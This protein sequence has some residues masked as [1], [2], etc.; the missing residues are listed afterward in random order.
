MPNHSR[1]TSTPASVS[2]PSSS[3]SSILT[4]T[5][6]ALSASTTS[7]SIS[8]SY[9]TSLSR[10]P[11][12]S[13]APPPSRHGLHVSRKSILASFTSSR[14][15]NSLRSPFSSF[16]SVTS[17]PA[18]HPSQISPPIISRP[19]SGEDESESYY[20]LSP[21]FSP[22]GGTPSINQSSRASS[23]P[24]GS[25]RTYSN[26][27]SSVD[28]GNSLRRSASL[29]SVGSGPSTHTRAP[30]LSRP[31]TSPNKHRSHRRSPSVTLAVS[32]SSHDSRLPGLAQASKPILHIPTFT[33]RQK[34]SDNF[35][36]VAGEGG[37]SPV[38]PPPSRFGP[39]PVQRGNNPPGRPP[40]T[41][42]SNLSNLSY[43]TSGNG[44]IGSSAPVV[45]A[46]VGPGGLNP[47]VV[48]Q[49]ILD[50]ASKRISTLDY[51]RKA[52]EG[53][54][55]W[56]NTLLFTKADL[57]KLPYFAAPKLARRATSYL[58]LGFSLPTVLDLNAHSA[59]DYLRALN[60]LLAEFEAYQALHPPDGNG[61][62][63]SSL[64]RA[65]IPAMFKRA[66]GGGG[67]ARRASSA[68]ESL[69]GATL[70]S[71]ADH[72]L[73]GLGPSMATDTATSPSAVAP[74]AADTL[75][76]TESYTHLLTPPLPF[77]PDFFETFATLCDVLIDCYTR[78]TQLVAGPEVV[79]Q[80][81]GIGE[82]FAKADARVR[83]VILASAVREFEE[84]CRE[85]VRSECKGVGRVVLGGLI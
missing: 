82:L 23:P 69:A 18:P 11:S 57:L 21:V 77:D 1:H 37:F 38:E 35:R 2:T 32:L 71:D 5:S 54:V 53:R 62:S 45:P 67:K 79:A 50:T 41:S 16:A 7:T 81:P 22:R 36:D 85:G 30:S 78:I 55:Y 33:K 9:S 80:S 83:K 68:T 52:H 13:T 14:A 74:T 15:G 64:S 25:S 65:R 24:P 20:P 76:P 12:T 47:Q 46:T 17:H 42:H 75:L 43:T 59:T 84:R 56:F 39:S 31:S 29:R 48:Y 8:A 49:N 72:M 34:S 4:S 28:L 63:S 19:F 70:R 27:I 58:L 3:S 6:A 26:S 73:L 60:A 44:S 66:A 61:S 51:L 10:S 40:A